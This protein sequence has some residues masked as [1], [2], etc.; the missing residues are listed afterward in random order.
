MGASKYISEIQFI[1]NNQE[2]IFNY[3]SNF[4]NLS[5][6]V[7]EGILEKLTEQVRKLRSP[8]LNQIVIRAGSTSVDWVRPEFRSSNA[9]HSKQ[10]KLSAGEHADR[11]HFVDTTTSGCSLRNQDAVNLTG[12]MSYDGKNDD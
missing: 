9:S 7:N 11:N 1:N 2:I 8:I 12:E 4:E 6:Y 10:S 3:L 5:K